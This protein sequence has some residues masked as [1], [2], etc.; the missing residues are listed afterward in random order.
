MK[1][2]LGHGETTDNGRTVLFHLWLLAVDL[3]IHS[4]DAIDH[5]LNQLPHDIGRNLLAWIVHVDGDK[6]LPDVGH[7]GFGVP[8]AQGKIEAGD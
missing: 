8:F 3:G 4:A 6:T 5:P 1:A 7:C 2:C